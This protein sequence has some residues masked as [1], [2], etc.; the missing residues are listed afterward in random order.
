MI[1]DIPSGFPPQMG[2]HDASPTDS[3]EDPKKA[4]GGPPS[5]QA[6]AR[7]RP[8]PSGLFRF[9]FAATPFEGRHPVFHFGTTFQVI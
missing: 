5:P 4:G 3:P 8:V 6:A 2:F 7:H 9:G 1:R